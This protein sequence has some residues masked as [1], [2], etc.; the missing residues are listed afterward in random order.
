MS[1]VS[2]KALWASITTPQTR[3]P[4]P[5]YTITLIV[6]D[7]TATQFEQDGFRIGVTDEGEKTLTMK[8]TVEWTDSEG[9]TM[10]NDAPKLMDADKD[11]LDA[12]VGNGSDVVVQFRPYTNN[13]GK[14]ME[15]QAVQV[16]NLI[17]YEG[18]GP[19]DGE[20]F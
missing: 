13:Y 8:R 19:A 2:G 17:E 7:E 3:F 6:D 14:F 10:V 1:L 20:E 16:L 18:S 5:K 4:P 9:N 12:I 11:P 15:L